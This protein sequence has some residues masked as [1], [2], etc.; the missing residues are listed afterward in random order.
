MTDLPFIRAQEGVLALATVVNARGHCP[1][2]PGA[3]MLILPDGRTMGTVGGGCGE[4]EI[5]LQ[6]L[7]V[8]E[9]G[10]PVFIVVD[11]WE[12]PALDDSAVCGGKM[13]V[14]IEPVPPLTE[15]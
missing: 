14:F 6:G 3:K 13:E 10:R 12:D 9:S 2:K 7:N 4:A 15:R 5:R 1:R 8:I 11:L